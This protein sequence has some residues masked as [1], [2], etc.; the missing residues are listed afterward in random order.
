[1]K[2]VNSFICPSTKNVIR[3][4]GAHTRPNGD[5]VD[6]TQFATASQFGYSYEH[7]F[8]YRYDQS[9]GSAN[10]CTDPLYSSLS[11]NQTRKTE[12]YVSTRRHVSASDTLNAVNS[13][14]GPSQTWLM[15]D[16]DDKTNPQNLRNNYPDPSENHKGDGGNANFCDGH[17]Q[18][19]KS[20]SSR[21][22]PGGPPAPNDQFFTAREL[23]TDENCGTVNQP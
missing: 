22:S 20:P 21:L 23:S 11:P 12:N 2:S 15:I 5:L 17:A 6:L 7:F 8:W 10:E 1:M 16:G 14:P 9:P 19:L 4:D 18:F 13:I 3:T